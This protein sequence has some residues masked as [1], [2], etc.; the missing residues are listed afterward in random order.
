MSSKK[1]SWM[2][3][4]SVKAVWWR[5][6]MLDSPACP[7]LYPSKMK[8]LRSIC[9]SICLPIC[10]R[11][12]FMPVCVICASVHKPSSLI[13][14]KEINRSLITQSITRAHYTFQF[15]PF[16]LLLLALNIS[17]TWSQLLCVIAWSFS[18][19][20]SFGKDLSVRNGWIGGSGGGG[21]LLSASKINSGK[22][23]AQRS[24][25]YIR[26]FVVL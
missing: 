15:A 7:M 9:L 3:Y 2:F 8:L 1:R 6:R 12:V 24:R 14:A 5:A 25:Q 26:C 18:Q 10:H 4:D 19:C 22:L 13:F 16:W 11:P 20:L 21:I 17:L 23:T